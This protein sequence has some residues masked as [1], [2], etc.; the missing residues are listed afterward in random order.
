MEAIENANRAKKLRLKKGYEKLAFGKTN[1]A[2][3]LLFQDG[4]TPEELKKLDLTCLSGIRRTKD[5]VELCFYDRLKAL[6]CLRALE[7]DEEEKSPL[8][9]ALMESA[10]K[11]EGGEHDGV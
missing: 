8:Y 4:L 5:T 2:V 6:D 7:S 1:D 9:R 10:A 3:L 11:T